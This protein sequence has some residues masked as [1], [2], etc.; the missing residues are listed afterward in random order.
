MTTFNEISSRRYGNRGHNQ[1]VT[2][3]GT[4]RCY[5]TS[6]NH[7]FAVDALNLPS[8]WN[9]LFTNTNDKSNEGI[10]HESLPF[11]RFL[12]FYTISVALRI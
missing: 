2:H 1:P 7:G 6:Q 12:N 5:M 4:K 11:F 3:H 9:A 10:V 8:G